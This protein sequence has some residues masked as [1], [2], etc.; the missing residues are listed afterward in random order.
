MH[1]SL[2][3]AFEV[4]SWEPEVLDES[5]AD[6]KISRVKVTKRFEGELN[7]DSVGYGVMTEAGGAP[8]AYVVVERVTAK[9][10]EREGTFVIQHGGV[11]NGATVVHQWGDIV[12]G[13]GSGGFTGV[14]GHALFSHDDNGAFIRFDMEFE[15]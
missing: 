6:T 9:A 4:L 11:L 3:T 15:D 2:N 12:P 8:G 1:I 13:T 5:V 10:H 14:T 7:G